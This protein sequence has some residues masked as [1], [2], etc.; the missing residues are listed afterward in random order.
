MLQTQGQPGL[1][2]VSSRWPGLQS[3]TLA[4]NNKQNKPEFEVYEAKQSPE[5]LN[6]LPTLGDFRKQRSQRP[7]RLEA[8]VLQTGLIWVCQETSS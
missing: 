7:A 1:Y 5:Q 8:G 3:E 4:K 6:D 2:K